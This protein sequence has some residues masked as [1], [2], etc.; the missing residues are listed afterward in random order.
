M[1]HVNLF[2]FFSCASG[3]QKF[4]GQGLG[5]SH[6]GNPSHKSDNAGSLSCRATG[7]LLLLTTFYF[8]IFLV[9]LGLHLGHMEVPRLGVELVLQTAT[10]DPSLVCI[11]HHSSWQPR[12]LNPW[13]K[14]RDKTPALMDTK[15]GSLLLSHS[16]NSC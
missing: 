15:S 7:E 1:Y 2:F 14:T 4:Q 5:Q 6:I 16:R 8:F 10:L 3:M 12:I 9:F 13:S 11:L